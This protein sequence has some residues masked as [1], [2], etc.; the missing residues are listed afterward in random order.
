MD[1]KLSHQGS[2]FHGAHVTGNIACSCS[3]RIIGINCVVSNDDDDD[4]DDEDDDDDD[5]DVTV[6]ADAV[7]LLMTMMMSTLLK[8]LPF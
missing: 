1:S 2:Q 3:L 6:D 8:E 7:L 5:D 4:D